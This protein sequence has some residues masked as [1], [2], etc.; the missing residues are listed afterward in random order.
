MQ[1]IAQTVAF[2]PRLLARD[3]ANEDGVENSILRA[4][5]LVMLLRCCVFPSGRVFAVQP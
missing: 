3:E 5:P 2:R 4:A 1:L